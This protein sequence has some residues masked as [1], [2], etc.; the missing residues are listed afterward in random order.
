MAEVDQIVCES[1][2]IVSA[3]R[4]DLVDHSG[5]TV[6]FY[7]NAAR[8]VRKFAE[9]D[10]AVDSNSGRTP[11]KKA[12]RVQLELTKTKPHEVLIEEFYSAAGED[13]ATVSNN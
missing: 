3:V 6:E 2:E 5:K 13:V 11:A 10:F 1:S 12:Y 9:T 7:A 4:K 8:D